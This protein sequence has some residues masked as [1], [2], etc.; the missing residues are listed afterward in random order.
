MYIQKIIYSII[1]PF[2]S[3][4]AG[5]TA[6]FAPF[7]EDTASLSSDSES[8]LKSPPSLCNQQTNIYINY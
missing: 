3:A 1:I 4:A 8:E 7:G 2:H 6:S 5:T